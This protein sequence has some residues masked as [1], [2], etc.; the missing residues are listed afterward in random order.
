MKCN[1]TIGLLSDY[2]DGDLP[3]AVGEQVRSHLECCPRCRG[4][5]SALRQT[6]RLVAHLGTEKCPVDLKSHVLAAIQPQPAAPRPRL[7]MPF[8]L[9]R[10]TL[11]GSAATGLAA[12]IAG[13]MLLRFA[14]PPAGHAHAPTAPPAVVAESRLHDQYDLVNGLGAADGLML[15]LPPER[16]EQSR[17]SESGSVKQ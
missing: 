1:Q 2:L 7:P 16:V 11:W 12:A 8:P 4:E 17:P 13:V 15:S 9:L 10:L 5:W 3:P 14:G 6:V